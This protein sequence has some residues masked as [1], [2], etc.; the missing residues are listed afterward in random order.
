MGLLCG[1][2]RAWVGAGAS[3]GHDHAGTF[4]DGSS[5]GSRARARMLCPGLRPLGGAARDPPCTHTPSGRTR[6]RRPAPPRVA[7][8]RVCFPPVLP[9]PILK[10]EPGSLEPRLQSRGDVQLPRRR[11]CVLEARGAGEGG[12]WWW[13]WVLQIAAVRLVAS[14]FP[15]P[16]LHSRT[17]SLAGSRCSA[18]RGLLRKKQPEAFFP[19]VLNVCSLHFTPRGPVTSA[20]SSYTRISKILKMAR[21]GRE[22]KRTRLLATTPASPTGEW[23]G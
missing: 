19:P 10:L 16:P 7:G 21:W 4:P 8:D 9:K 14:H 3:G 18:L 15:A 22:V 2:L 6:S 20:H 1:V 13:R 5:C 23:W 17:P 12:R 11:L